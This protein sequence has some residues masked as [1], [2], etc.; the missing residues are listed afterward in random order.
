VGVA[1]PELPSKP[2]LTDG[3]LV[4]EG[5]VSAAVVLGVMSVLKQTFGWSMWPW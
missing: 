1:E 4:V 3:A 5:L 2:A